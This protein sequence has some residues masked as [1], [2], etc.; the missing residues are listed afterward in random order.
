VNLGGTVQVERMYFD[1]RHELSTHP[2]TLG[3]YPE[4]GNRYVY[5]FDRN[6]PLADRTTAT[7][8]LPDD[9]VGVGADELGYPQLHTNQLRAG[10]PPELE[11]TL[12]ITG[13]CPN[14][15]IT[16]ACVSNLDSDDELDVRSIS[17]ADRTIDGERVEAG[18]VYVHSDDFHP[19]TRPRE[20][21]REEL[22]AI[23][24]GAM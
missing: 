10:L 12:G 5:L 16:I 23:R 15:S 18:T 6:G 2:A 1:D 11:A 24:S 3:W 19:R 4:R 14:C 13:T 17:T 20:W 21:T 22:V 7:T 8:D 9:V